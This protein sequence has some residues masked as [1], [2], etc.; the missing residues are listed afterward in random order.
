VTVATTTTRRRTEPMPFA[1]SLAVGPRSS[2]GGPDRLLP[3]SG[4]PSYAAHLERIGPLPGAHRSLVD[5]VVASGLRGRG[6]AGFPT[7]QKMA[8]AAS[9][10]RPTVIVANATEGEPL[11]AKDQTLLICN[12]HLV[13]DGVVAAGE[14]IGA[15]RALIA[16]ERGRSA[17]ITALQEAIAERSGMGLPVEVVQTPNRYVAGQE[18]ALVRWING[19]DARPVFGSRPYLKGVDGRPTLVDNVETLAHI[20]L[21]A[22]F[23]AG[24]FCRFGTPDE[25]GT[26]L[27]TVTGGV[28]HPGVYEV[29]IGAPLAALL[30]QAGASPLQALLLG[31]Y[32]GTWVRADEVAGVTLSAAGLAP[33]GAKLG[34]GVVVCLPQGVCAWGEVATVAG[35]YS[36]HSTGQCG[37]CRFG[38]GD[39]ASAADRVLAGDPEGEAAA[40]RWAALV[41]GRGACQFPDGAAGFVESA[42]RVFGDEIADH[43]LR[44]CQRPYSGYLPAPRPGGWR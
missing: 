4:G 17:P 28:S 31:G 10:R 38:L 14:A 40:R 5:E 36:A 8:A 42:V 39:I 29:P 41:R 11:S 43:R 2:P 32:F 6:G 12:P 9:G 37:P 21:I 27:V 19:G 18:T 23:G 33:A 44:R 25:P 35:W 7:G 13:L 26:I 15:T 30:G 1:R 34:C 20:G 24:W 16:I 3:L 22:R